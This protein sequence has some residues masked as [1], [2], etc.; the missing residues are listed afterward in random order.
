MLI[1][2]QSKFKIY[3][4]TVTQGL[5]FDIH[6]MMQYRHNQYSKNDE[7]ST[8]VPVN[9]SILKEIMGNASRPNQQDYMDI[10]L[11]YCGELSQ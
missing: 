2:H 9:D 10:N 3:T 11:T 5:P 4:H 7:L 1:A 6:S 8:L